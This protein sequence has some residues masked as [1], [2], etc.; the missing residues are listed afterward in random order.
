MT[1]PKQLEHW[2]CRRNTGCAGATRAVPLQ[3]R[4][5]RCNSAVAAHVVRP[6]HGLR[7]CKTG[8]AFATLT[9]RCNTGCACAALRAAA[10]CWGLRP[11]RRCCRRFGQAGAGAG[12]SRRNELVPERGIPGQARRRAQETGVVKGSERLALQYCPSALAIFTAYRCCMTTQ[13]RLF[14]LSGM[15]REEGDNTGCG[16]FRVVHLRCAGLL[17]PH[18][19]G[20]KLR[21]GQKIQKSAYFSVTSLFRRIRRY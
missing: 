8:R 9:G 12:E 7:C 10:L 15:R 18:L 14:C 2:L 21:L 16:G 19:G 1:L 3:Q 20:F 5:W 11:V 6:Q 4:L 17:H 13:R